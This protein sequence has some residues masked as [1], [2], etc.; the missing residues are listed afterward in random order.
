[1]KHIIPLLFI[2]AACDDSSSREVFYEECF[3]EDTANSNIQLVQQGQ[4]VCPNLAEVFAN[5]SL[6]DEDY[7]TDADTCEITATADCNPGFRYHVV[8]REYAV[9][10]EIVSPDFDCSTNGFEPYTN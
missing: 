2:I 1:M 9:K 8:M 6:S 3:S 7:E 5:C 4:T 10:L